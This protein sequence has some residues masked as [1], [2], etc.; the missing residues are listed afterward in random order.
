[1]IYKNYDHSTAFAIVAFLRKAIF[2][3]ILAIF[4]SN[5]PPPDTSLQI[6]DADVLGF[7]FHVDFKD[8]IGYARTFWE[9][10][11]PTPYFDGSKTQ[12]FDF[13]SPSIFMETT[14]RKRDLMCITASGN[15][16][17]SGTFVLDCL[18]FNS[19]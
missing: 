7:N 15:I 18:N 6:S 3:K 12:K 17:A 13:A 1:M 19:K 2:K 14:L 10:V 11:K 16:L 5:L 8:F 4:K 9:N